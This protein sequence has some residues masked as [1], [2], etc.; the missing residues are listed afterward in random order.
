MYFDNNALYLLTD[1]NIYKSFLFVNDQNSLLKEINFIKIK[2]NL[3][4]NINSFF[5]KNNSIY[6]ATQNG[7][8]FSESIFNGNFQKLDLY[9]NE[10]VLTIKLLGNIF[11]IMKSDGL[12][13]VNIYDYITNFLELKLNSLV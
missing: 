9:N 4:K 6:L 13:L 7:I 1:K 10:E 3:P 12:Y 8:W 2:T 11:Y 5:V